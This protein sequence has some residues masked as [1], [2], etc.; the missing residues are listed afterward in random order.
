MILPII[1][2]IPVVK[3]CAPPGRRIADALKVWPK[4][5]L[6]V[7]HV[8]A[9]QLFA[10]AHASVWP[11]AQK[12]RIVVLE[13]ARNEFYDAAVSGLKA[14]LTKAG[15]SIVWRSDVVICSLTGNEVSDAKLG[16]RLLEEAPQLFIS[17]GTDATRALAEWRPTSPVLFTMVL[18][19]VA[20]GVIK[21]L[22]NPGGL[23]TGATLLVSPGKQLEALAQTDPAVHRVVVLYTENDPTSIALLS[24]ARPDAARLGLDL[25]EF[26]VKPGTSTR[27]VLNA[28]PERADALWLIPDP[29]SSGPA[30][31]RDS[32]AY[33]EK[34]HIPM[35]GDSVAS[36]QEGA[37]VALS[38]DLEDIGLSTAEM[39][40]EILNSGV[41]ASEMRVRGPRRTLLALNVRVARSLNLS[42]SDNYLRLVDVVVDSHAGGR[43][44]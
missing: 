6:A 14:G 13:S 43:T 32:L 44:R 20:L 11:R 19:P 23:F 29:A 2:S 35:L 24:E 7:L 36:V 40:D 17:V 27:Q 33:T 34:A 3:R 28:L 5:T 42:L 1:L 39:A 38:P 25:E 9:L 26:A 10:C 30:A 18:D 12:P 4:L 37:L 21:S 15:S 16:R 22:R 41:A 31:F 8:A